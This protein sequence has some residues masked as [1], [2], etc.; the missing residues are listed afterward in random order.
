MLKP[1]A[2]GTEEMVQKKKKKKKEMVQWLSAALA[3][4]LEDLVS[5][6]STHMAAHDC[7]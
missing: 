4:L 2:V 3:V 7:L 6:P 1:L 5:I